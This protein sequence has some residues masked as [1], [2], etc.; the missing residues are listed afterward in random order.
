MLR[1]IIKDSGNHLLYC[2][3]YHSETIPIEEF[4]S[5]LKH[6]IRKKSPQDYNEIDKEIKNIIKTK[7]KKQHLKNYFRHSFR[8]YE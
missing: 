6:Y 4:F 2:V 1:Q 5:Q 7:I 3:P 8:I